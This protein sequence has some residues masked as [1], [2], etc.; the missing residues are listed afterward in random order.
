MGR[1]D[2]DARRS[3]YDRESALALMARNSER[4]VRDQGAGISKT[5]TRLAKLRRQQISL[6][7]PDSFGRLIAFAADCDGEVASRT[8]Q[9]FG[10]ALS[11]SPDSVVLA[12]IGFAI[13]YAMLLITSNRLGRFAT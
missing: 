11:I 9:E 10:F 5:L 13:A 8:W 12:I 1:F 3:G 4:L 7:A 2:D 6:Q